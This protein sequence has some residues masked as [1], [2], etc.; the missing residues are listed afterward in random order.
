MAK[1]WERD[2]INDFTKGA[3]PGAAP[4]GRR[5]VP[6]AHPKRMS[7][8]TGLEKPVLAPTFPT[9]VAVGHMTSPLRWLKA[10]LRR[11]PSAYG[12]RLLAPRSRLP[13]PDSWLLTPD[14]YLLTPDT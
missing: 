6:D 13:A 3:P 12:S 2:G 10:F 11:Y 1:P 5:A 7:P 8:L 4:V 9:A 14:S